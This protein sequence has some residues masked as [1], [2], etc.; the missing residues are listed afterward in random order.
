VQL[1]GVPP[2]KLGWIRIS[3]FDSGTVDLLSQ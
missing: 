3:G 1:A 2:E